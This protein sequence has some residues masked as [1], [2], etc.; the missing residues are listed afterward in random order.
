MLSTPDGAPQAFLQAHIRCDEPDAMTRLRD[1]LCTEP[2]AL[3]ILF[4]T[5]ATDFRDVI[6]RADKL[7]GDTPV[8]ACTTAGEISASGY[9]EDEIVAVG[10]PSA[11]FAV[12]TMLI[13]T[14]EK[15]DT[16]ELIGRTIRK[17]QKLT[18]RAETW[19]NEFA[20][21]MIDG[22]SLKEDELAFGLATGLGPMPLFGGSAGDGARFEETFVSLNGT[23]F[24]N[25]AIV[26][27]VRTLCPVKVFSLDH[28]TPTDRRLV[29]TDADPSRRMVHSLNAAPA[30]RE[31]ARVL[32]KD[33]EQLGPFTFAAHP[34]V[35][36]IGGTHHVRAIQQVTEDGDLVFFSA[37]DEGLVLT[38][39]EPDD[40]VAH[41]EREFDALA[42]GG[43]PAG[44][45]ACDCILRRLEAGQKQ[46]MGRISNTLAEHC[47]VGFSTYGEQLNAMHVNHTMTGVAI[48]PPAPQGDQPGSA[49]DG[50][51]DRS[52]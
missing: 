13:D 45:I 33:P 52:K 47:V 18:R 27:F 10:L 2:L 44:I 31:Y 7:F 17:R 1:A 25:A 29:V 43:K 12:E 28:L 20:F 40:L 8:L 19:E 26:T 21:L 5:P 11:L 23:P 22:L 48:Y 51:A 4:V 16:Q 34:V 46:M 36:T 38:L 35:V 39:A 41:L 14:L 49:N 50:L 9:T 6:A 24:Q 30:A 37:I 32:G 42:E 3:V 15:I